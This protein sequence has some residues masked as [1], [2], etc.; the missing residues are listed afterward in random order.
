MRNL[1]VVTASVLS[2]AFVSTSY[3]GEY[4]LKSLA[5]NPSGGTVFW[6]GNSSAYFSSYGGYGENRLF[7]ETGSCSG[8]VTAVFVWQKQKIPNPANPSQLIDDILDLPP[9]EVIVEK[10][11]KAEA[12][13]Y[14]GGIGLAAASVD[15]GF[16]EGPVS[17]SQFE[18]ASVAD[19]K[20]YFSK[21]AGGGEVTVTMSPQAQA[22]AAGYWIFNVN[23]YV[24]VVGRFKIHAPSVTAD[25]VT[26]FFSPDCEKFLT[27]QQIKGILNVGVGLGATQ[28]EWSV[29]NDVV[30][31][32][33]SYETSRAKGEFKQLEQGDRDD[34][35]FSFFT[36]KNGSTKISC[37]F[38]PVFPNGSLVD[39]G[40]SE[41]TVESREIESV[42]PQ[43]AFE[44]RAYFGEVAPYTYEGRPSFAFVGTDG[45]INGMT[46]RDVAYTVPS[47]F[48]SSGP[49][50]GSGCFIQLISADRYFKRNSPLAEFGRATNG[51][52]DSEFPYNYYIP[53]IAPNPGIIYDTPKQLLNLLF[54]SPV[55]TIWADFA[56]A[57]DSFESWA[58]YKPPSIG[59]RPV[60]WIPM[61][62]MS[63]YWQGEA[64]RVSGDYPKSAMSGDGDSISGPL[65]EQD[66]FPK[67]T[68]YLP[69]PFELLPL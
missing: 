64:N 44:G 38:Q 57:E 69:S 9:S 2:V 61:A 62:Y 19:E 48:A 28:H 13:S 14:T 18:N 50:S 55:G 1:L 4:V 47:P 20:T 37:K 32:F 46:W 5:K 59:G 67:W 35:Q 16:G 52:L 34:A 54:P 23:G 53:G 45:F 40:L 41:L 17:Q 26:R 65:E 49:A 8:T 39:P 68:S 33:R 51:W 60:V 58:M 21:A 56:T 22:I 3:A 36:N 27:G 11:C 63:W 29:T 30:Q 25:G 12:F 43:L 6:D 24:Q 15:L 31:T 10:Y 7:E 42:R 66:R